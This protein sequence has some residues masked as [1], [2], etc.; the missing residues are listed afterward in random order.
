MLLSTPKAL[1]IPDEGTHLRDDKE[2][3]SP[4]SEK[5]LKNLSY[6]AKP[7]DSFQCKRV[8]E[9]KRSRK[10]KAGRNLVPFRMRRAVTNL[11]TLWKNN[12]LTTIQCY[13]FSERDTD[14]LYDWQKL[15]WPVCLEKAWGKE[16]AQAPC[17]SKACGLRVSVN[18]TIL[19]EFYPHPSLRPSPHNLWTPLTWAWTLL[20]V[21]NS[22]F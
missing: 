8:W 21:S 11:Q 18:V 1:C 13:V 14:G 17:V 20:N 19:P 7:D 9:D 2:M 15:W 5:A 4:G 12:D 10:M 6:Q 3:S 22:K 16:T